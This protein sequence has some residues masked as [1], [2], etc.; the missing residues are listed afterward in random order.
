MS[1]QGILTM[2]SISSLLR[3]GVAKKI[4]LQVAQ[5][6]WILEVSQVIK[7]SYKLFILQQLLVCKMLEILRVGKHLHELLIAISNTA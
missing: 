6:L 7:V 3:S 1:A 4:L 5:I 2:I